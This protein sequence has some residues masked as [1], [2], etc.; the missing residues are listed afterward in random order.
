MLKLLDLGRYV[1]QAVVAEIDV[2]QIDEVAEE[3]LGQRHQVVVAQEQRRQMRVV[4][5]TVANVVEALVREVEPGPRLL[6][7]LLRVR[8]DHDAE[9]VVAASAAVSL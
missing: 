5:D 4:A 1:R 2:R 7:L 6:A 8:I 9:I 3:R